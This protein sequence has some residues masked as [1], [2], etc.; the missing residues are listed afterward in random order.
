MAILGAITTQVALANPNIDISI[1]GPGFSFS[2]R[3]S[4]GWV[5][6]AQDSF[7]KLPSIGRGDSRAEAE[8]YAHALA[9]EGGTNGAFFVKTISCEKTH[10]GQG[11]IVVDANES[12]VTLIAE[13]P[14]HVTCIAT[15]TFDKI[16]FVAKADTETEA[17]AL[18]SRAC[19]ESNNRSGFFCSAQCEKMESSDSEDGGDFF[20]IHLPIRGHH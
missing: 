11:S 18:A 10:S 4:G 19:T 8:A 3:G 6:S 12:G 17:N 1:S 14:S 2:V 20:G 9:A 5:C 13:G 7:K 16:P 15:D